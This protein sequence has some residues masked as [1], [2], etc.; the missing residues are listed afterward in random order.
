MSDNRKH[1]AYLEEALR[2]AAKAPDEVPVGAVIVQ[3]G[4]IIAR[5]HN[6]RE[7]ADAD[8]FG[9]AE[10]IAMRQAAGKLAAYDIAR[11]GVEF[12]LQRAVL[13]FSRK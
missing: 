7:G 2:E 5:A 8:P 6:Q 9:H 12:W 13:H 3:N 1:Q 11:S 4:R 10:I